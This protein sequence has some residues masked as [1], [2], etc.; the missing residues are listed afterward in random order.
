MFGSA[1]ARM[2]QPGGGLVGQQDRGPQRERPGDADA[3]ALDTGELERIVVGTLR[4]AHPI[5]QFG[6]ALLRFVGGHPEVLQ[7][8]GDVLGGGTSFQQSGRLE[9]GADPPAGHAQLPC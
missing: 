7:R 4:Q 3:L 6:D 1:A 8:Q 5:E 2:R 9:H